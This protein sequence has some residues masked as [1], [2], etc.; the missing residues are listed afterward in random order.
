MKRILLKITG[1]A[2][3][4]EDPISYESI[5]FLLKQIKPLYDN[6]IQVG[7]VIGGGNLFRGKNLIKK[8]F[9]DFKAHYIGM[10]STFM[11]AIAIEEVFVKNGVKTQV[12]SSLEFNRIFKYYNVQ[13][14]NR[15]FEEN[16]ICIFP[17]GTGNPYFTTDSAA[18]LR[19]A[20]SSCD[21]LIKAT[22]VDGVYSDDPE[23]NINAVFYKYISYEDYLS[24]KLSILDLT[25]I[26]ICKN[27]NIPVIVL[28]YYKEK[29]LE[30]LILNKKIVGSLIYKEEKWPI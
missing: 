20:E 4:K 24:K 17:G 10:I 5:L 6:K 27:A 26:D 30:D 18:A 19:A 28:N 14:V 12:F 1:E 21:I 13:D 8:G 25:A 11:N 3:K 2:L 29:V 7:I 16:Y 22:K 9:T 23:K 15:A